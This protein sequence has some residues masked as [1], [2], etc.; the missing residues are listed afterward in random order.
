M[1]DDELRDAVIIMRQRANRQWGQYVL[2]RLILDVEA[3]LKGDR[4]LAER[5]VIVNQV[6]QALRS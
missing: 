1:S 5:D 2:W 3:L 4:T 6:E